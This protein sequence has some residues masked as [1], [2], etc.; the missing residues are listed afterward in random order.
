MQYY[1]VGLLIDVPELQRPPGV[2]EPAGVHHFWSGPF[3][4]LDIVVVSANMI[5]PVKAINNKPCVLK[6]YWFM[7]QAIVMETTSIV[8]D[9]QVRSCIEERMFVCILL[10]E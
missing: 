6:E 10:D 2:Q 8:I 5:W 7:I 9:E 3:F 4:N 1:I